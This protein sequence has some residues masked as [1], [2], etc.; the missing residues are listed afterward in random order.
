METNFQI[1]DRVACD[2]FASMS[3]DFVGSIE[4]IYENSAVVEIIE[5]HK[6]DNVAVT[7]FHNRTVVSLKHMVPRGNLVSCFLTGDVFFIR[8]ILFKFRG[9]INYL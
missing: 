3:H 2:K 4:K 5:H 1:G 7:D 8:F 6:D 9:G